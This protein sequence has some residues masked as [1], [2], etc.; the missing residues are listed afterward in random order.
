MKIIYLLLISLLI[1]LSV[2]SQWLWQNPYPSA[3]YPQS[4]QFVDA[5]TCFSCGYA[6]MV[7]KSVNGGVNWTILPYATN[8]TLNSVR[9]LDGSVIIAV[10]DNGTIIKS[11]DGGSFWTVLSSG[12]TASLKYVH[13][14]DNSNVWVTGAGN[15]ILKSVN[16]G[17]S[18]DSKPVTGVSYDWYSCY[19]YDALTGY[20]GGGTTTG[21]IYKTVN[22]GGTW[23]PQTLPADF[24]YIKDLKFLNQNMGIAVGANAAGNG[25][26]I[27]TA[28]GGTAWAAQYTSAAASTRLY[29]ATLANITTAW[30]TGNNNTLIRTVNFGA[31]ATWST[32]TSPS[33]SGSFLNGINFFDANNGI[34]VGIDGSGSYPRIYKTI[35]GGG[36]W[37]SP[38]SSVVEKL[39]TSVIFKDANTGYIVGEAGSFLSS[40]NG[41]TTWTVKT[42]PSA[43]ALYSQSFNDAMNGWVCGAIGSIYKT[44]NGGTSWS[45][46]QG[47]GG[48]FDFLAIQ[49]FNSATGWAC[50]TAGNFYRTS[51]GSIW[52]SSASGT[53]NI[54]YSLFFIDANTGWIV[55]AKGTIR[56]TVNGGGSFVPQSNPVPAT[57]S[58]YSVY[59][60]N[61]NTGFVS[62]DNGGILKTMDGGT[63]WNYKLST[64]NVVLKSVYFLNSSLGW[65]VGWDLAAP[66]L[67]KEYKTID[68]GETWIPQYMNSW[69]RPWSVYFTDANTGWAV[70]YFS[71]ILK[72]ST[73]G[74]IF[75][76]NISTEVPDN[77]SLHQNY[78]NPFNPSTNIKFEI[79][80][81]EN[82]TLTIYDM[83]GREISTLVNEKLQPGTYEVTF[84]G[85][86]LP[87]GAYFY[88]LTSGNF[89]ET[90]KMLMIK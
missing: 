22:G 14:I 29:S 8:S 40:I 68:S 85:S 3:N 84:D 72:T 23:S 87:S 61:P 32:V 34:F 15:T 27:Y 53:S 73:G 69:S 59:F 67:A 78:P 9:T 54:L 43:N 30:V 52:T 41:G 71:G 38:Y 77:Y 66:N 82:V 58:I 80:K 89:V 1:P 5:N 11:A 17:T 18:W 44:P 16:G 90:K 76:N 48:G 60:V 21:Y 2:N 7:M 20:V 10:G 12:V 88:K 35:N 31:A 74:G 63:T 24:T 55:G 25:K 28:N 33:S 39:F 81:N 75:V 26:I 42:S 65:A 49:M 50:G 57:S 36:S 47:P 51:D 62:T 46:N 45:A 6:G 83:L 64:T 4:V 13:M 56:K 19:F 79:L 37:I 86:N 70:G